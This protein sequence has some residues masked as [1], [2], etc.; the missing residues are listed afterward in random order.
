[1]EVAAEETHIDDGGGRRC[2]RYVIVKLG[3]AAV[4]D[5]TR[6]RCLRE[7]ALAAAARGVAD[8]LAGG[9]TDVVVV[10]GAGSFGHYEARAGRL[11]SS[12]PGDAVY[13]TRL[14][15][16]A[17]CAATAALCSAVL[18]ALVA[19]GVPAV[20]VPIF[21][22]PPAYL[23]AALEA[24][25]GGFVPLLHG[26]AICADLRDPAATAGVQ[27]GDVIALQLTAALLARPDTA[28][29]RI[30]FVTGADGVFTAHPASPG[31][32]LVARILVA[33][34]GDDGGGGGRGGSGD[35]SSTRTRS[36]I[37][38]LL[39]S[40]PRVVGLVTQRSSD[41]GAAPASA[42]EEAGAGGVDVTG[43]MVEKVTTALRLAATASQVP[44]TVHIVGVLPP[45]AM[46]PLLDGRTP[47]PAVLAVRGTHILQPRWASAGAPA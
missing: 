20:S 10:H 35:A 17:T 33:A 24:L 18:D 30:V 44:V 1:M 22:R 41:E 12:A 9:A 47:T 39:E 38:A 31:A 14:A 29:V 43:G 45:P 2:R 26:D 16:A 7:E 36:G 3:G 28:S 32:G 37:M 11:T 5:K 4:T 8:A 21:P 13:K 46:A 6:H 34:D 19:A 15:V 40:S 23:P 25:D 27:S 42:G